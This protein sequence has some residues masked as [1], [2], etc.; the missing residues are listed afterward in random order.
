MEYSYK[1]RIYPNAEQRAL[2]QK[3]FGCSR[4]VYNHFLAQRISEYKA[5]GKAPTRFQQDKML[6]A[7][8]REILWLKEVDSIPLQAELQNLDSAYQG[9]FHRVKKGEKPG[10]PRFKSKR[11]RRKSYKTKQHITN[12]KPTIYVD[13]KHIRLP[14][15]GLV[16]CRISKEVKGRI[17]SA[18]VSQNPSGK[19]FVAL[20]CTDVEIAPLP[21]TGAVV[22]LDMGLKSFAITSDGVDYENHRHLCKSQKKLARLQRQLSRKTKGSKRWEKAK[23]Q[24]ARLHEHITNQRTDMLHKLSTALVRDYDL[25]SIED[26]APK[27]M[28]KNH[29]LARSIADAS[30][31][32]FRRQLEYKAAWYG[33]AVVRVDKFYPSSQL[34]SACGAQW[35]GTKDLSVREWTCPVC[36]T[37]HDRDVN[38]A[39]NILNEGLRLLA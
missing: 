39:K 27:N 6:T 26:L 31:G 9:F 8:K 1:F 32:E 34:C 25:I 19:Y 29:K 2:I 12:G 7:L 21:S 36:G 3:T 20:C 16:K 33:K 5:T 17:L 24:V 37:V 30:W 14:K 38:A 35:P 15:L 18:T 10:F 22:G 4:F 11:D 13:D 28:V 23:L